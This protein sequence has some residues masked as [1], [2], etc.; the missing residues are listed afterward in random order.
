MSKFSNISSYGTVDPEKIITA[1][2]GDYR[3]D[4]TLGSFEV[5][6]MVIGNKAKSDGFTFVC[7][8]GRR[9]TGDLQ[10]LRMVE[11]AP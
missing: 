6:P 9:F 3:Y 7:V 1:F 10:A 4:V 8:E 5:R 11:E 2:I